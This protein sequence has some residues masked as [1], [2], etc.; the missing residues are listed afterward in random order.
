MKKS[1]GLFLF[2]FLLSAP[3]LFAQPTVTAALPASGVTTGG[4]F[5]HIR[6]SGLLGSPLLCPGVSCANSVKFGDTFAR[7]VSNGFSEIVAIAPPHAA[8]SV[9]VT[10]SIAGVA[11]PIVLTNAYRYQGAS[12]DEL[13]R[14][15]LPVAASGPGPNAARFETEILI[16]N[17]GDE[18]VP[19]SG[20]A[21]LS[22]SGISPPPI[23]RVPP[24]T[25]GTFTDALT[26]A[27]YFT[28]AFIY[29]PAR[30]A[31]DVITKVRVH[32]TSRDAAAFGVEIP[33][34]SDLDFAATVRLA[35]IPTDA[36]FRSTLRVYAYDTR[37]F[38]PVT[39][40]VRDSA[41]G[42]LLST[43]PLA[44]KAPSLDAT[45]PFPAAAQLSLDSIIAPLR[46]HARLRIDIADSDAIR[47]IWGFVSITNNETQE[48]TLVTPQVSGA[49]VTPEKIPLGWWSSGVK[50]VISTGEASPNLV[51]TGDA[52]AN[53]YLGCYLGTFKMPSSLDV[54]GRFKTTGSLAGGAGPVQNGDGGTTLDFE[55]RVADG[56]LTLT[57]RSRFGVV[58]TAH[59]QF[60]GSQQPGPLPTPCP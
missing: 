36:R 9:D 57:V 34:V 26:D 11:G 28:G 58:T 33:V 2:L 59:L 37:N 17:A 5:V 32:D 42:T 14:I 39:L 29:V 18:A 27:Q 10:V 13:E 30:L 6:G 20:A 48:I 47:P 16:T 1:Y 38:G 46:S 60:V 15:L 19:V 40:R 56:W 43:V 24:H 41:D 12:I 54:D 52:N 7:I 49:A 25:T 21:T 51:F 53:V 50:G 35:G 3:V 4:G 23:P 8:G 44:L 31:R 22:H 55:G 45:D